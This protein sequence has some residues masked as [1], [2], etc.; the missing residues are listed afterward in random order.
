MNSSGSASFHPTADVPPRAEA[1]R[2]LHPRLA[3]RL[4]LDTDPT[5]ALA[6]GH[7][8]C[9]TAFAL[10][11][12]RHLEEDEVV[13]TVKRQASNGASPSTMARRIRCDDAMTV[14]DLLRAL[15]GP[16]RSID[17]DSS[18]ALTNFLFIDLAAPG[19]SGAGA[20]VDARTTLH[21][22]VSLGRN[23]QLRVAYDESRFA[24]QTHW[25]ERLLA[26]LEH[27][28]AQV[29][30]D[31][32]QAV[33]T[34]QVLPADER[35]RLLGTW[36]RTDR[37]FDGELGIHS[38]FE[39]QAE[40]HPQAPAVEADG[41]TLTYGA[42]ES[43]ANQLAHALRARGVRPGMYVG[44]CLER[45]ANLIVALL[46][47]VKSGAA[48]V[49][50]DPTYPH[51]RLATMVDIA[52]CQLVIAEEYLSLLFSCPVL[53]VNARPASEVVSRP[54]TRPGHWGKATQT[55]YAMFTSGSSG[56]PKGAVLS[57]RAVVNTLDWVCRTGAVRPGDR[58]LFVTSPSFDLS[59][60][61]IFGVLGA[62][63][64]VVVA[65]TAVLNDPEVLAR[66][67]VTEGITVWNST[68]AALERLIPLLPARV[69]GHA[70]GPDGRRAL[71]L[72]L[73]SGDWIPLTLPDGI[74]AAFPN[75]E[76]LA[77]GGATEAAIW[78]NSFWVRGI[79]PR[80]KSIP[81][82]RPIQNTRY[83]I[84][85]RRLH[86]TPIGVAGDLYIGGAC[87]ADGYLNRPEL[88]AQNFIP[89]PFRPG[90]RL[91]RTGDLARYFEDGDIELLGRADE[92][93][94]TRGFRLEPGEVE[95]AL[96]RQPG[97]VAAACVARSDASGQKVP[98]AYVVLQPGNS[99]NPD[100]FREALAETLP[101]FMVPS[102][103]LI[104][105]ALPLSPNGKVDRRALARGEV[106]MAAANEP[107]PSPPLKPLEGETAI[108]HALWQELL[109]RTAIGLDDDFHAL[110]GHSLLAV[111]MVVALR[112]R[113]GIDVPLSA[114]AG[115]LTI[116]KLAVAL[117]VLGSR[118]GRPWVAAAL[119]Q[120]APLLGAASPEAPHLIVLND[121]GTKPPL[122]LIAGVGGY[123]FTYRN[124]SRLLGAE[125]PVF[126]FQSVGAEPSEPLRALSIQEIA[127]IYEEELTHVLPDGPVVL[128]GFSIGML[129]AFEL[130]RRLEKRGRRVPLLISFDGFAPQYP[131]HAPLPARL[132]A[133][134][135]RAFAKDPGVRRSYRAAVYANLRAR[136]LRVRG[137]EAELA[138]DL[139][140]DE[141]SNTRAKQL[142]VHQMRA[143]AQYLPSGAVD[144][145]LL[146]LRVEQP[147]KWLATTMDDPLYGWGAFVRGPIALTTL[148]GMHT[149]LL[150][151]YANQK[152]ATDAISAHVAHVIA[153]AARNGTPRA[154]RTER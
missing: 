110:G 84:L 62:G 81:Y 143:R 3:K 32:A 114:L 87:L 58:L 57:H 26:S 85:D 52:G 29:V 68:P 67:L 41:E 126:A 103:I 73:L 113:L 90:E 7:A 12:S 39:R 91:Y 144:G 60:F 47:V 49:P 55:C 100:T 141:A 122:V 117:S 89:D 50:L 96:L 149:T 125:Q 43:R 105:G 42:L 88:T 140:F 86:P 63:A 38:L 45:G 2:P 121:R 137:R 111:K 9:E 53:A 101:A 120:T 95:S 77:L 134:A 6:I 79:D 21:V 94:K 119:P 48:Y 102:Q 151:S 154:A 10:V 109:G 34:V 129:P 136:V 142:W 97:V 107:A 51:R 76:I 8:V 115:N 146:L 44:V 131:K 106:A 93:M 23:P 46:A 5:N 15:H 153:A 14:G 27:V 116:A 71:R 78:S 28:L 130:A 128:G 108:I 104:C 20:P 37:A 69:D 19:I 139:P 148:P 13:F 54:T 4:R 132:L 123:A 98:V 59:V 30:R 92:Q 118:Q 36:N 80:W 25:G 33:G 61:D 147:E 16:S 17:D 133:H 56:E 70:A 138:P 75:A 31:D 112:A 150:E 65:S 18:G 82:G 74:R 127:K 145:A 99:L 35:E 124:F 22:T 24:F 64:T 72:V 40:A 1:T 152:T 135:K 11:L 66:K 83:H